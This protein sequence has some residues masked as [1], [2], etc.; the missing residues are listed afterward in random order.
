[1]DVVLDI[2]NMQFIKA[3]DFQWVKEECSLIETLKNCLLEDTQGYCV[4]EYITST[5]KQL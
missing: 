4:K 2:P 5:L 3:H 1:M